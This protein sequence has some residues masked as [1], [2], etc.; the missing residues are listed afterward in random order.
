MKLDGL[1]EVHSRDVEGETCASTGARLSASIAEALA[2]QRGTLIAVEPGVAEDCNPEAVHEFRVAIRRARSLLKILPDLVEIKPPGRLRENFTWI[3]RIAGRQRDYDVLLAE[4]AHRADRLD[5]DE[6]AREFIAK[7]LHSSRDVAHRRLLRA[8]GSGRYKRLKT[9][10]FNLIG[11]LR[12]Y[13]RG[14]VDLT[15][16]V[17]D[18]VLRDFHAL[19]RHARKIRQKG[20][21][22]QLHELRKECKQLR[23]VIESFV[24]L[25]KRDAMTDVISHLRRLQDDLGSYCDLLTQK[26]LLNEFV[27]T[28]R[29]TATSNSI[30][31]W[32][33]DVNRRVGHRR[34]KSID[35]CHRFGR[36]RQG[37]INK[38]TFGSSEAL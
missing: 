15:A 11:Q 33:H 26:T 27:T 31:T 18:V 14:Q 12:S 34:D 1:Q 22:R 36:K 2:Q 17:E 3:A 29:Q 32:L 4:L 6:T 21:S 16:T 8:L 9:E 30:K 23:Y 25:W 38:K 20:A 37:C 35:R 19:C 5:L 13:P 7:R 10:W 28:T 24:P